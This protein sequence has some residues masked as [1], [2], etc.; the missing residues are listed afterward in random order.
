METYKIIV[1]GAG[2]GGYVAALKAAQMGAKVALIEGH[3]IGGV[4]LNYGCIPTKT[5]LKSA[6]L[7]KDILNASSFGIDISDSSGVSINWPNMME[8]KDKV[9]NQLVSGVEQ[10]LKHNNVDVY[11]GYGEIIDAKKV[12]VNDQELTTENLI[13][14]T[15][16]SSALPPIKGLKESFDKKYVVD[17][18]GA[19]KLKEVPESM[20]IL[21]GGVIAIEFATLYNSLGTKVT[22]L[23]RSDK[24]LKNLDEE[25]QKLMTRHM[26]KSGIEILTGVDMKEVSDNKVIYERKGKEE[27][28]TSDYILVSLGRKPNLKGLEV[29]DLKTDKNGVVVDEQM[30]TNQKNV[31]AIGD[32]CGSYMLAHVASA[33]GIVAV[34]S[35]MGVDN[36]INYNKIP[37]CIYSFPEVGVVG[38]TEAEA[39]EKHSDIK[40]SVFPLTAN[41]KALAEGEANGFVKIVFEE[42]YGEVLGVHIVAAHA[43]DMIAEAVATMTLEGTIHD[44]AQTVHPHPTLS[45]IVM[46][47][48]HGALDQ[49]IHMIKK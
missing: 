48:A 10:L 31:Y 34:E 38:L 4:C 30:R 23:Q 17:S 24:I 44:L 14:A 15:G 7:Y 41:G 19:I 36:K 12:K 27:S 32:M 37:S 40:T 16:S 11:H 33:E 35:I 28:I 46:E 1:I 39:R 13:L 45:E 6:K 21:G 25:V 43:T 18:T 42:K 20:T 29:L 2:P 26:K 47:A 9:V 22:L 3:K 49:P 8:R 5:L